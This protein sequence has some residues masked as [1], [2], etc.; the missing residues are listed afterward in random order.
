MK[1]LPFKSNSKYLFEKII[2]SGILSQ[3]I[4]N[5]DE[6]NE[7]LILNTFETL[8]KFLRLGNAYSKIENSNLKV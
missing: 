4:E 5:L 2:N 6:N 3:I 8:E 1:N 7:K